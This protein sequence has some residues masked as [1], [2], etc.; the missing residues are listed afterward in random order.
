MREII[1]RM[2]ARLC[3]NLYSQF[4]YTAQRRPATIRTLGDRFGQMLAWIGSLAQR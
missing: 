3:V 4:S 2:P 1:E